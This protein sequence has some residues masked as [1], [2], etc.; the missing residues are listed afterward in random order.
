MVV[1]LWFFGITVSI[2]ASIVL[3]VTG[4]WFWL[5]VLVV[6]VSVYAHYSLVTSDIRHRR[7]T[8]L[9]VEQRVL[10]ID[11]YNPT[12]MIRASNYLLSMDTGSERLVIS[13]VT[14]DFIVPFNLLVSSEI[15][16]NNTSTAV[17]KTS[18]SSQ[19]GGA[20]VGGIL[21]GGVGAVVGGLSGS[22]RTTTTS[23]IS[24]LVLKILVDD[25]EKPNFNVSFQ[26]EPIPYDRD[27]FSLSRSLD[28]IEMWH[29]VLSIL[30]KRNSS[31]EVLPHGLA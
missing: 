4:H 3:V 16:V 28:D 2:I 12:K 31:Q 14:G 27:N 7:N 30:I 24:S 13:D 9:M 25:L 29:G 22:T 6:C 10:S 23:Q 11:N 20:L 1:M 8:F 18:R 17:T 5:F 21:A 15:V 19:L 26:T